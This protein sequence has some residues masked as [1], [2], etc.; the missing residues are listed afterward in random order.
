MLP[1]RRL[2]QQYPHYAVSPAKR[3]PSACLHPQKLQL[4]LLFLLL[5]L[6]LLR[7]FLDW[8]TCL[9]LLLLQPSA[10]LVSCQ[11]KAALKLSQKLHSAAALVAVHILNSNL[12]SRSDLVSQTDLVSQQY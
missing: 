11:Q 1:S 9:L 10:V 12:G 2:H 8:S 5:Q 6:A 7:K 4:L 3:Q